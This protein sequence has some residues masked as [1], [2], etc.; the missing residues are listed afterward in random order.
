M[1]HVKRITDRLWF[2]GI[3][4]HQ[5]IHAASQQQSAYAV[6]EPTAPIPITAILVFFEDDID[7]E[8]R[9]AKIN[10]LLQLVL[11]LLQKVE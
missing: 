1:I 4:Q 8:K 7:L 2:V 6:V 9:T 10:Q 3:Y 5:L 11:S